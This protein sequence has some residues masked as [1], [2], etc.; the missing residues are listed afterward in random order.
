MKSHVNGIK[1]DAMHR[2]ER[3]WSSM[4]EEHARHMVLEVVCRERIESGMPNAVCQE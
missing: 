2:K 4:K 1:E 3:V